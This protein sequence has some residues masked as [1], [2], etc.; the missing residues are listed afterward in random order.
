M[1][2]LEGVGAID[3]RRQSEVL[4]ALRALVP[5]DCLLVPGGGTRP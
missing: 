4:Q 2:K 5:E 1:M 3:E